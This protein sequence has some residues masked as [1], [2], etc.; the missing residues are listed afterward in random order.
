MTE[1]ER[2][3]MEHRRHEMAKR[4]RAKAIRKRRIVLFI[5]ELI[6][7]LLLLAVVFVVTKLGRIDKK[8][9]DADNIG[10]N[11]DISQESQEVMKGYKT[12][13]LFGLDNRSNGN[14]SKGRSDVIMIASINN[15]TKEVKLASVFRDTFL[16]VG[17][18]SFQKWYAAFA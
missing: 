8:T 13:A 4:R 12:I 9:I 3:R 18:G 6:V 11:E 2:R 7:L 17:G 16:D 10:I 14:L 5:M 1:Q 15:D